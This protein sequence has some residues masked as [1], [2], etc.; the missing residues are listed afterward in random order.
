MN[1]MVP[2]ILIVCIS[3]VDLLLLQMVCFLKVHG[4]EVIFE[5]PAN[6]KILNEPLLV[7]KQTLHQQK[8]LDISYL[9][10]QGQSQGLKICL[11]M[12]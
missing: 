6:F 3:T 10:P 7:Q 1:T 4:A 12:P 5:N 2:K 8:A 11:E 9:E